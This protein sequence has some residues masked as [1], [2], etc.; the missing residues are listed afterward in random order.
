[1][2]GTCP[3]R[4]RDEISAAAV[5]FCVQAPAFGHGFEPTDRICRL[6]K[7]SRDWSCRLAEV[8]AAA[9]MSQRSH[10]ITRARTL[11]DTIKL[12]TLQV[13]RS[14][15]KRIC[16]NYPPPS[17]LPSR[18]PLFTSILLASHEIVHFPSPPSSS[19]PLFLHASRHLR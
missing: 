7:V 16:L 3:K 19:S 12:S 13:P 9:G 6:N 2:V 14:R 1:M 11:K 4:L 17:C 15:P 10:K 18:P 5:P 8:W